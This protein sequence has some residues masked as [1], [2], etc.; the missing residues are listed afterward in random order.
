MRYLK[1]Q[2]GASVKEG[3]DRKP[4]CLANS[5]YQGSGAGFIPWGV[6][7]H[8]E[9]LFAQSKCLFSL[10]DSLSQTC[11]AGLGAESQPAR[12]KQGSCT[13]SGLE[14]LTFR[15]TLAY[16]SLSY[17]TTPR[18]SVENYPPKSIFF[19]LTSSHSKNLH[20]NLPIHMFNACCTMRENMY[21]NCGS[22][23]NKTW[24]G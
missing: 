23:V 12:H 3:W 18:D 22:L 9:R 13:P 7:G 21:R 14:P 15:K 17:T 1:S 20:Y 5:W 8:R 4:R 11:P 19:Y 6:G 2:E 10:E 24:R 16:Q